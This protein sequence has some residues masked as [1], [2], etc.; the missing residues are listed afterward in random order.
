MEDLLLF[1]LEAGVFQRVKITGQVVSERDGEYFMMNG[2]HGLRFVLREPAGIR[3]GDLTA[4]VGI[5]ELGGPSPILREAVARRQGVAPLPEPKW[6]HADNLAV[7][8]HDGRRVRI[9]A[10]LAGH[11]AAD[12][13]QVLDLQLGGR[14]FSAR[15]VGVGR[16]TP[17]LE[18]GSQ[19][20]LTG[21]YASLDGN[22]GL[23]S[24][25]GD[26]ELLLD[27][28][29]QVRV[30]NR[31]PWWTLRRMMIVLGTLM[32]VLL[33]A[34][35]WITQLRRRAEE[36]TQQLQREIHD[37]ERAE[38]QRAVA[39]EKSRIARDLHDDLGSSLTE[40]GLLANVAQPSKADAAHAEEHFGVIADKAR[41][42][43]SALDVMVW[44]V[45]P[46]ENNLQ[47]V[48][49]YVAGYA[50]EFLE[51]SGL[52][53]RFKIP[54]EMPAVYLDGRARHELFLAVN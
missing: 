47:S 25:A 52:A 41:A 24:T 51:A 50:A 20:E 42:M 2:T 1:D 3:I 38:Q 35:L 16:Q 46:E 22:H 37:R 30:M 32:A 33:F 19:L 31:P 11:R 9:Q 28:P 48:A 14:S 53:C 4:V 26:F 7:P 45:D 44:A 36:R 8:G 40:I 54:A 17:L 12:G 23:G 49:D 5:P 10:T 27:S 21:V 13:Y 39:E 6:L 43:V 18:P 15:L 34:A 29:A